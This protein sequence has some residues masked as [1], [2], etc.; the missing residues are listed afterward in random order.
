MCISGQRDLREHEWSPDSVGPRGKSS[1]FV[2][3]SVGRVPMVRTQ[4]SLTGEGVG[5][6]KPSG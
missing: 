1:R 6:T 5:G 2:G 3:V 4:I